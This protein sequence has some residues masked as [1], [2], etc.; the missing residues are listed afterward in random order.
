[1]NNNRD[2]LSGSDLSMPSGYEVEAAT[3]H[4]PVVAEVTVVTP[5]RSVSHKSSDM[6][7]NVIDKLEMLRMQSRM[8]LHDVQHLMNEKS[9]VMKGQLQR[10]MMTAKAQ[11]QESMT[12][13]KST[14]NRSMHQANTTVHTSFNDMQ[15]DMKV[16]PMKWA[17]IAAGSGFAIGLIGRF[18]HWRNKHSHTHSRMPQLVI[19]ESAC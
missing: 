7:A 6:K 10:S 15:S 11:L 16:N 13:A 18:I 19:I 9:V 1:M 14:M 17:G 5:E 3:F 8:K 2:V 12:V 4:A